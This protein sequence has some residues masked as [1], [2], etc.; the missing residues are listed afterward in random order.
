MIEPN[1]LAFQN[2]ALLEV[3]DTELD[4]TLSG[5]ADRIT[6]DNSNTLKTLKRLTADGMLKENPLREGL[7]DAG[8]A[9]LAA[10][11]RA[12]H[13]GERAEAQGRWDT[14]KLQR[15]PDNRAV[16][17]DH[18]VDIADTI[19]GVGDVLQPIVVSPPDAA[20]RRT[21]WAGEHRWEAVKYLN[22]LGQLPEVLRPG[23]PFV[24]RPASRGEAALIAVIE[25]SARANDSP[26]EDAQ[27]LKIAADELG[28]EGGTELARRAGR[29]R[30]SRGGV[31]DVQAK[32]KV[33][34]EATP[35]AIAAY[36][37][38]PSAPN[39]WETLRD[40]VSKPKPKPAP[41]I[42]LT[43]AQRLALAELIH[44]SSG[45]AEVVRVLPAA[46]REEGARLA[47]YGLATLTRHD[48][49]D[50]AW[51]SPEGL[52]YAKAEG[53]TGNLS[54][55]REQ[56]G[57]PPRHGHA[58][59]TT[60]WLNTPT[61]ATPQIVAD[62][63]VAALAGVEAISTDAADPLI[64][65]GIRHPNLARANEA[66]RAA[67][68]M[69]RQSNSGSSAQRAPESAAPTSLKQTLEDLGHQ[70]KT[71]DDIEAVQNDA[72]RTDDLADADA[73]RL[74]A[75]IQAFVKEDGVRQPFGGWAFRKHL[76]SL[77]LTGP[78]VSTASGGSDNPD[79]GG[80]IWDASD[81]GFAVCDPNGERHL[82]IAEAQA[83]LVAYA[84]NLACVSGPNVGSGLHMTWPTAPSDET[85]DQTI[86]RT[87]R[88]I[89]RILSTHTTSV[90]GDEGIV[91]EI[92]GQFRSAVRAIERRIP[93]EE[94]A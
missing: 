82:D 52:E 55:V 65:N 13:G 7:T 71:P 22:N 34:R 86:V 26:W 45:G 51:P 88:M 42:V 54:S 41:E 24:E 6:R 94:T 76:T 40:S 59:Y 90:A 15:N 30:D 37:A 89:E 62:R 21:I 3:L 56:L 1:V 84:L 92:F 19:L 60:A 32:L 66:R 16:R 68:I 46:H 10:Y 43:K 69:P 85:P 80:V 29:A 4:L 20:G 44:K 72:A 11:K 2:A 61:P 8:R 23:L 28:I 17:R 78:F 74:L 75:Q 38:D 48:N 35:E 57:I 63:E 9:Q 39:A 14:S 87:G 70:C 73:A 18:V 91:A 50:T 36:E 83:E 33:A 31:R 49:G 27:R 81:V 58:A 5:L 67:G 47:Q 93:S 12:K 25:N 77:G 79:E 53:L 64:V